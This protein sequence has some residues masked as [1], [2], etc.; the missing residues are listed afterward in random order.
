MDLHAIA[1]LT[2]WAAGLCLSLV[3]C[4]SPMGPPVHELAPKINSTLFWLPSTISAGDKLSVV[5]RKR[6]EWNQDVTV[7]LDGSASFLSV[8]TIPVAGM[9]LTELNGILSDRYSQI[10]EAPDVV[11][12]IDEEAPRTYAI[13]GEVASP[14]E[15]PLPPDR[16]LTLLEAL[17]QA[18][19]F[20]KRAA[21]LSNTQII[22]WVP[23]RGRLQSFVF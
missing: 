10:V 2:R 11:V 21:W 23:E 15:Y 4:S 19:G 20:S 5:F 13:M 3:A 8:G 1:P 17:G 18:S 6:T 16:S 22:R 7:H 14:G 9:T 12:G